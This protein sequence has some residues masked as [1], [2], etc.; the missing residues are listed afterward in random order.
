MLQKHAVVMVYVW[1]AKKA[2]TAIAQLVIQAGYVTPRSTN[3]FLEIVYT[4][5]VLTFWGR[6]NV[7][8]C[9]VGPEKTAT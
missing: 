6:I 7:N 9:L 5:P 1:M 2:F 8:V 4:A 3:A